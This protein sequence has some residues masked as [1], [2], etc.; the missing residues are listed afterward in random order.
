MILKYLKQ[1]FASMYIFTP[2]FYI[3]KKSLM[4][5]ALNTKSILIRESCD[6]DF[7]Y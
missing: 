1:Y 3:K 6:F 2:L 7:M 4:K 5:S